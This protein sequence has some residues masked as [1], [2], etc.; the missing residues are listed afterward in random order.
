[1]TRTARITR[2]ASAGREP[3]SRKDK[4]L[5]VPER[6]RFNAHGAIRVIRAV[7]RVIRQFTVAAAH[8]DLRFLL[9]FVLI[10]RALAAQAPP[11]PTALPPDVDAYIAKVLT[12]WQLPGIA[13]AVVRNDSVLVSKGYG[14]REVGKPERVDEHTIFDAASLTKSFT[15]TA[16]A[17]LV[18]EGKL[19]WDDPVRR[20]LPEL[21]LPDAYLTANA[22]VRDFLAHRTGLQA[23][24][25]LFRFTGYD[26]PEI[27]ARV[28]Y[29]R[30]EIPFRTGLVYSNIGYTIAGEAGARAAGMS[31][32]ALIRRR[33]LEPLGL[34]ETHLWSEGDP[35]KVGNVARPHAVIDGVQQPIRGRDNRASTSPAGA[36]QSSAADLARWM[37]FQLGDGT[38]EGRRLVS[39][40][41]MEAMHSPQIVVPAPATF[42]RARQLEHHASYGMG[43]QVWDYRGH[44]LLWHSGS[45][46]G[47]L[48]YMALLPKDR[49]GVVVLV[50]SWR[51]PIIHGAIANRII[52]AYL[53]LPTRDYSGELLRS[54]SAARRQPG[55]HAQMEAG[56]VKGTRPSRALN[57]YAGVFVDSLYGPFTI[58]FER[59]SLTLQMGKG[60]VADLTHWHYDTFHVT[61]RTPLF[62]EGFMTLA[63]F[64]LDANG[65]PV[66]FRMRLNRDPVAAER[67]AP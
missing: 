7:I 63:A 60:E 46:N 32:D 51:A 57:E 50:N 41:A 11:R 58:R 31:Y 27:L 35:W 18:D 19:A 25:F 40:S 23:G 1:M 45:G 37:R 17:M 29:L 67:S 16:L 13:I 48:A 6:G 61:W 9:C 2:I 36:V 10:T 14:V 21:E 28:R 52:D 15:A 20:H 64:T 44:A 43:W 53:G 54:D 26:R 42:R 5:G 12:D 39:D 3:S 59:D 62:R 55:G 4:Q 8:R 47:Q 56:R 22:T 30:K 65:K 24:N 34:R 38:F 49:L 66:S 33:I